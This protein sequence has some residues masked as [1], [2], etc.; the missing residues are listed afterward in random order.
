MLSEKKYVGIALESNSFKIVEVEVNSDGLKLLKLDR[1]S[2]VNNLN[3]AKETVFEESGSYDDY[4]LGDGAPDEEIFGFEEQDSGNSENREEVNFSELEAQADDAEIFEIGD[5]DEDE[6]NKPGTNYVL[7]Y[8]ILNKISR[9]RIDLAVN[10]T[11]GNTIFQIL[12]D[13]NY[14]EADEKDIDVNI[15]D[16]LQSIYGGEHTEDSYAYEVREDG[17]MVLASIDE[18]PAMLHLVDE[19]REFYRGTLKIKQ[20]YPDEAALVGVFRNNYDP[21]PYEITALLQFGPNNCRIVF[22][23]GREILSVS[24][25]INVGTDSNNFLNVLFSKL[26][27]QL[28]SGEIPELNRILIANN[29][30]GMKSVRFFRD[31]FPD[32]HV[33]EFKYRESFLNKGRFDKPALGPFT[34]AIAAAAA[35]VEKDEHYPRL[36][37]LPDYIEE[38]QKIFKLQWHGLI[39]LVLIFLTFPA[40]N[41]FYQ[42]NAQEIEMLSNDLEQT[43]QQIEQIKPTV[44]QANE[45][46]AN[47]SILTSKFS[48]LDSLSTGSKAWSAKLDIIDQRMSSIPNSW[49]VSM[50]QTEEGA[51]VEGYTLYRNRIPAIVDIFSE[52]TLLNV[53]SELNREKEIY[54]FSM[55][56]QK[57]TA[58]S[59]IYSP[60]KPESIENI[61]NN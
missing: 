28:D 10:V 24:T 39:M 18:P 56:V 5:I 57:F 61:F 46:A 15:K 58:D 36:S 11:A 54:K 37:L 8:N 31:N 48:V 44:A 41:Y 47:L 29:S 13:T 52:A 38:R 7:L 19:T 50:S 21:G 20:V 6:S 3:E 27:F 25:T 26:L 9:D 34:T 33:E 42:V 51:F 2:L 43:N 12:D 55:L 17:S 40:A 1:V 59:S 4:G 16:R 49:F 23:E 32:M 14:T 35:A 22:M 45:V 30:Q 60:E 53:N